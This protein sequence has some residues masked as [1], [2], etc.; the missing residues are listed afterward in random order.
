M[1]YDTESRL[2]GVTGAYTATFG[3]DGDGARLLA[4]ANGATTVFIGDY[5]EYDVSSGAAKQYYYA[6]AAR[7]AMRQ[8]GGDLLCL[9]GD[10]LGSAGVALA[11]SGALAPGRRLRTAIA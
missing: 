2:L 5:Y 6:G 11:E 3:Y 8:G 1:T 4:T 7:I 10:H 9:L